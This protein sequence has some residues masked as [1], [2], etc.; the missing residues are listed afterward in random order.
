MKIILAI[1]LLLPLLTSLSTAAEYGLDDHPA[2]PE[3]VKKLKQDLGYMLQLHNL[4]DRTFQQEEEYQVYLKKCRQ[5]ADRVLCCGR[6]FEDY[7]GD[8]SHLPKLDLGLMYKRSAALMK[9]SEEMEN[10]FGKF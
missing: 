5:N 7:N 1:I 4:P 2:M 10:I 8:G 6:Q 3:A 9:I